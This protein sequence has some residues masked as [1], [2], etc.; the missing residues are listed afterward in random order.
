[1]NNTIKTVYGLIIILFSSIIISSTFFQPDY[2][3]VKIK[4]L[5]LTVDEIQPEY[6]LGQSIIFN[7]YLTNN[8][9]YK[10]KVTLPEHLTHYQV[11]VNHM[12]SVVC[13]IK[14]IEGGNQTVII[15]SYTDQYLLTLSYGPQRRIGNFEIHI[16]CERLEKV[17][18]VNITEPPTGVSVNSTGVSSFSDDIDGLNNSDIGEWVTG[19]LYHKNKTIGS[20]T[21]N[22]KSYTIRCGICIGYDS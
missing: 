10:V 21:Y 13:G 5:E 2:E 3:I 16:G 7:V 8:H 11:P 19:V 9:P 18:Y 15:E 6:N 22:N 4:D 14:E 1:M 12:G 20:F 17:I